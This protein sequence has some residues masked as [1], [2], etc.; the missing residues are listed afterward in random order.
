MCGVG[1]GC[2]ASERRA[3]AFSDQRLRYWL[4]SRRVCSC[5]VRDLQLHTRAD[6]G[7]DSHSHLLPIRAHHHHLLTGR[8]PL[9]NEDNERGWHC[10]HRNPH[11]WCEDW[12][13]KGLGRT[14]VGHL[15]CYS[16]TNCST[17]DG[18]TGHGSCSTRMEVMMR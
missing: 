7:G 13:L 15:S 11:R 6:A 1:L 12:R 10:R 2:S 17:C 3:L 18:G 5:S 9:R 16:T 8:D 14:G 4:G